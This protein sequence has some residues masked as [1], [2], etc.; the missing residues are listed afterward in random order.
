MD[1]VEAIV[2]ALVAFCTGVINAVAGG[3]TLILFPTLLAFGYSA[4]VAN[5]TNTVAVWPG[6][7]GGSL[8]Y[9]GEISR[10]R[11]TIIALAPFVV[12]GAL[13]GSALLLATPDTVFDLVV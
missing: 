10:Q 9:R 4:K 11:K 8:A 1:P 3:G 13:L 12:V 7:I 2:L 5:V 6:T